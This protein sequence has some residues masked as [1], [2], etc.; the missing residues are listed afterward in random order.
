MQLATLLRVSTL[1]T[2]AAVTLWLGPR[3]IQPASTE[4]AETHTILVGNMWFCGPE[5]EY[6]FDD[7]SYMCETVIE[8]GD[9]VVWDFTPSHTGFPKDVQSIIIDDLWDS[10]MVPTEDGSY[11]LEFTFE[12]AGVYKYYSVIHPLI[13]RGRIV[14]LG[15]PTLAGDADCDGTVNA[16]DA[17]VVL[18]YGEG[19]INSVPCEENGDAN[20]DGTIDAIDTAL[21]LQYSASI[22]ASLPPE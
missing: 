3:T 12:Q 17:A 5:Y 18:Q 11:T 21:I 14:V 4:A 22:I 19:I 6:D 13:L 8:V 16:I 2:F 1:S 15:H 20:R 9:T 7:P 10:G